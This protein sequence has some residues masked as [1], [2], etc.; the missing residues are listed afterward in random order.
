MW[1]VIIP[2]QN[3]KS[4]GGL[5]SKAQPTRK[6]LRKRLLSYDSPVRRNIAMQGV[7]TIADGNAKGKLVNSNGACT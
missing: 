4:A 1:A 7:D 2:S 3:K 5:E 6:Y